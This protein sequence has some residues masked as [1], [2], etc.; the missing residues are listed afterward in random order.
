M[1]DQV[2]RGIHNFLPF[3]GDNQGKEVCMSMKKVIVLL[4][5]LCLPLVFIACSGGGGGGS[6]VDTGTT[7]TTSDASALTVASKV[8]VVDAKLSGSVAAA[9]PLHIGLFRVT[10]T[11]LAATTDYKADK[12]QVY[13][14]ERSAEVFNELN[15]ILCMVSQS[16]YDAML[17][18][19]DYVALVDNN[20]CKDKSNASNST[21]DSQNQSS[22]S[23][24][25]NYS[26]FV[27]NSSRVD[28]TSPEI[29]KVWVHLTKEPGK[30]DPEMVVFVRLTITEGKSDTNPY[31]LFHM[32]L[33]GYPATAGVPD[34]SQVMFKGV[35]KAEK[36]ANG[37]VLLKFAEKN[38]GV[39][40]NERKMS[41]N[42]SADGASG[43]GSAYSSEMNNG[44]PMTSNFDLAFDANYFKRKD[45]ASS[46]TVCLDR[47]N[48][49]ESAWMYGLYDTAGKR[50]N[51]NS[52]FSVNTKADGSGHYGFIG[53]WGMSIDNTVT[54]N[55][56]DTLYKFDY[57][58]NT[59]T[60]YTVVMSGGKLKK[61]TKKAMTLAEIKGIPLNYSV[62]DQNGCSNFQ[63]VWNGADQ[64][65]YETASMPQNCGSNCQWQNL[66]TPV[67]LDLSTLQW[68]E[69]NFWSQSLSGQVRVPLSNCVQTFPTCSFGPCPPPTTTCDAPANTTNVIFF[70]EDIVYPTDTVPASFACYD[71]CPKVDA[72]G[73]AYTDMMSSGAS[74]TATTYTFDAPNM[75][76]K[77]GNGKPVLM[78]V[79]TTTNSWGVMSG[80]MFDPTNSANIAALD[81]NWDRDN[82][83]ATQP[84]VCGWKAWSALDVFYTWETGP[85]NWNHFSALK[86]ANG[87]LKFETPLSV[88]YVH[89]KAGSP[90]DGATFMLDYSGF[91]NL[92]GIPG[93][94]V[95]MDTGADVDCGPGMAIKWV[96][97]FVIP[98][99][100]VD[101][102]LTKVTVDTAEYLVKP[103]QLEQRMKENAGGCAGLT[104]TSYALPDLATDW[105]DPAIGTEPKVTA[106]PAVIG[107]VVQ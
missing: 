1:H 17:N 65:F 19:G 26:T 98:P 31:G 37:Q 93:K 77:D 11:D 59:S 28:N 75:V 79:A 78:T 16:K 56:G 70:A 35:M 13:V 41:M 25:P 106:A 105:T 15:N 24:A 21:A 88:K 58:N 54:L 91:G 33:L 82:N 69:L 30:S 104:V 68:G 74:N 49:D 36:D 102:S 14:S 10:A 6:A 66:A 103:L 2:I 43:T 18:K 95:S 71:N 39:Y 52:G 32:E 64:K 38:F 87:I 80:A 97:A 23:D 40:T 51:R 60:P 89:H 34:T 22:S 84:Q 27:V 42:R 20:Q 7:T 48:F 46:T 3:N 94:C 9:A 101:G 99:V 4:L 12:P 53:Y 100:Q 5:A 72:N 85:G 107:G 47:N 8:S 86:D 62:C 57:S 29:A 44:T 63:V 90:L 81:C 67:A 50:V 92:N 83:P 73:E 76:L 45:V 61:H 55:N 96:P